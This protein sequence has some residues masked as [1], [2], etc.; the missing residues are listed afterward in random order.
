MGTCVCACVFMF[1]HACVGIH[2]QSYT[3]MRTHPNTGVKLV[4]GL[5]VNGAERE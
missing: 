1:V 2:V 5:P 3:H 4:R